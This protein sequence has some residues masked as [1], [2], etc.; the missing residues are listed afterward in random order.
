MIANYYTP[1]ERFR[2]VV[3]NRLRDA[4]RRRLSYLESDLVFSKCLELGAAIRRDGATNHISLRDD[5]LGEWDVR[6]RRRSSDFRVFR[7]IVLLRQYEPVVRL[8]RLSD[9]NTPV[10]TIVDAGANIGLASIHLAKA[11]PAARVIAVEPDPDNHAVA[12]ANIRDC[13][14]D[15]LTALRLALWSE[16]VPLDVSGDYRDGREW[17]RRV[18]EA[19]TAGGTVREVSMPTFLTE[20][21]IDSIDL[22]KLDIEGAEAAVFGQPSVVDSWLPRVRCLAVEIHEQHGYDSILP[23]LRRHGFVVFDRGD[24]T[25]AMSREAVTP[26]RLVGYFDSEPLPRDSPIIA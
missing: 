25:L 6:L 18:V 15:N 16:D 10:R 20:H 1:I 5:L 9:V 17:S 26:D 4:V 24:M 7:Q 12:L 3:A 11:F 21:D 14:A 22:L 23:Q 19:S 13:G 2:L 8:L